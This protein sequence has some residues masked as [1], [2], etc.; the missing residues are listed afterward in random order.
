MAILGYKNSRQIIRAYGMAEWLETRGFAGWLEIATDDLR[1]EDKQ[2]ITGEIEAHYAEAV[3]AHMTAGLAQ[4]SAQATAL[5]EL[6]DPEVAAHN[7]KK[8]HLTESDAKTLQW[9]E[10]IS[11]MP[12]FSFRMLPLDLLPLALFALVYL[13][14]YISPDF[15]ILAAYLLVQYVGFRLIPRLLSTK[16]LQRISFLKWLAL[17]AYLTEV[18]FGSYL[19][20]LFYTKNCNIFVLGFLGL[21]MLLSSMITHSHS[22]L[23][24]WNKLRKMGEERND[25]PP[26]QTPAS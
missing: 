23:R 4:L 9:I 3:S 11:S 16:G 7:F 6:G 10:R 2:R 14:S 8:S 12:L 17:S 22:S 21:N 1:A 15:W 5:E 26:R 19:A 13:L 24:I 18:A 20:V 25:L